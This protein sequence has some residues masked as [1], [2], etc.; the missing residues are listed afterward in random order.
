M[1]NTNF[2]LIYINIMSHLILEIISSYKLYMSGILLKP[3]KNWRQ[4]ILDPS[5]CY[6]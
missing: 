2:K 3:I 1:N 5:K 6:K 4:G